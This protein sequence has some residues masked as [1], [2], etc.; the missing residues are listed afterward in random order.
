MSGLS[1]SNTT[2]QYDQAQIVIMGG[3]NNTKI[4]NIGDKLR[5]DAAVTFPTSQFPAISSNFRIEDMNTSQGGIARGSTVTTSW[6]TVY[7]YTGNGHMFGFLINMSSSGGTKIRLIVDGVDLLDNSNGVS[8]TDLTTISLYDI[9]DVD[10]D[11]FVS[12]YFSWDN[13]FA[14]QSPLP[15]SYSTS[16]VIR[17]ARE[18]SNGTFRA[19]LVNITKN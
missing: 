2:D 12:S 15:I 16:V 11:G 7:S 8:T 6:S 17:I 9:S 1:D 18:S 4:G 13:V 10:V 5:T 19:G 3:T 14:F